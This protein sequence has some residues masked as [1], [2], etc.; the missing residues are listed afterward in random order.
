MIKNK[1]RPFEKE[2]LKRAAEIAAEYQLILGTEDGE[3]TA[4]GLEYSSALG[5]GKSEAEA[6]KVCREVL[7]T[8]VAYHLEKGEKFSMP[9]KQNLRNEQISLKVSAE[10]KV[11]IEAAAKLK[12]FRGVGDYLRT[13]ALN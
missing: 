11:R 13:L 5:I 8:L 2:I 9:S 4:R 3:F 1:N 10:E 7:T 6:I 12:G